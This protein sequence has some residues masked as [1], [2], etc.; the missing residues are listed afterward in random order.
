MS[1]ASQT[2]IWLNNEKWTEIIKAVQVYQLSFFLCN[3]GIFEGSI[4]SIHFDWIVRVKKKRGEKT[5]ARIKITNHSCVM[6]KFTISVHNFPQNGMGRRARPGIFQSWLSV[7]VEGECEKSAHRNWNDC[8]N[9]KVINRPRLL[10]HLTSLLG[11]IV[12]FAEFRSKG[13]CACA[14][15]TLHDHVTVQ[16]IIIEIR[17]GDDIFCLTDDD[18]DNILNS[19]N[20]TT[21]RR[22]AAFQAKK[23]NNVRM[24]F[25]I[26]I[27]CVCVCF[28]HLVEVFAVLFLSLCLYCL[29]EDCAIDVTRGR[30]FVASPRSKTT[31]MTGAKL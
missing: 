16:S 22:T 18:D 17:N 28:C 30:L 1:D 8:L 26:L 3:F 24:F 23:A 7:V 14:L 12:R 9:S 27:G 21:D 19:S 5:S 11:R 15:C 2:K 25:Y 29:H 10:S 20:R 31:W 4:S 13:S 6:Q